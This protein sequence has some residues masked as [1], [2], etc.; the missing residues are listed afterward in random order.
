MMEDHVVVGAVVV[1]HTKLVLLGLGQYL[2]RGG[3]ASARWARR[4]IVLVQTISKWAC[5]DMFPYV[6]LMYLSRGLNKPPVVNS[7]MPLDLGFTCFS[8]FCV[9]ST[10]SSLGI[11]A[12]EVPQDD[13]ARGTATRPPQLGNWAALAVLLL[14]SAG[15]SCLLAVGLT[16]SCMSLQ[17]DMELLYEAK[18]EPLPLKTVIE[19]MNMGTL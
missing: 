3:P 19:S 14:L 12:P 17:L 5:P 8:I 18:L 7:S 9:C 15:F 4:C 11:R 16:S 2:Q 1:T 10:V 6:L 13:E